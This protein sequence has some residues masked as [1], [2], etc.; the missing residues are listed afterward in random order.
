MTQYMKR[1][2]LLKQNGELQKRLEALESVESKSDEGLTTFEEL[3]AQLQHLMAENKRLKE[4]NKKVGDK[5]KFVG[6]KSLSKGLVWLPSPESR[7]GSVGDREKGRM[8]NPGE[9]VVVPALWALDYIANKNVTFTI[10]DAVIDNAAGKKIAPD[11]QFADI[12]IP[13][14]FYEY[15]VTLEEIEEAVEKG[16]DAAFSLIDQYKDKLY[17]LHKI[18]ANVVGKMQDFNDR[19]E[20]MPKQMRMEEEDKFATQYAKLDTISQYIDRIIYR[21]MNG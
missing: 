10:G 11:V 5:E 21:R 12:Q 1:E 17:I 8:L 19:I 14:E 18:Y 6:I 15:V 2:D 3:N 20:D 16:T 7:S 9:V 4:E 13:D